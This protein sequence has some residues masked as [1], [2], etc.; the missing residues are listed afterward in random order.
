MNVAIAILKNVKAF[1]H[2]IV[3]RSEEDGSLAARCEFCR[4]FAD[5]PVEMPR[6]VKDTHLRRFLKLHA[7]CEDPE[8]PRLV[9]P[10][11]IV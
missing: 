4:L 7:K 5:Y 2:V 11:G 9:L 1:G 6:D 8:K 10:V 3:A